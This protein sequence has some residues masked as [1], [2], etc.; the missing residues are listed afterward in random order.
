MNQYNGYCYSTINDAADADLAAPLDSNYGLVSPASY[1][2][3]SAISADMTYNVRSFSS[4]TLTQYS[5]TRVYPTCSA[6]GQ[7]NNNSGIT[8]EDA[9]FTS[10]AIIAAWAVVY[11]FKLG[12][13]GARG[14]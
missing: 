13:M 11:W 12:K 14:Y 9:V 5:V 1:T 6:V 2:V 10:W 7:L 8:V 4:G 3:T